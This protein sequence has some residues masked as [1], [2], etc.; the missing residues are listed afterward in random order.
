MASLRSTIWPV[1]AIS[2]LATIA[3]QSAWS[4]ALKE[5]SATCPANLLVAQA[6]PPNTPAVDEKDEG[7]FDVPGQP[8]FEDNLHAL[9]CRILLKEIEFAK[10]NIRF[11][12][13]G[14]VQGRWRGLRYFA[15]QETNS[16]MTVAGLT[17]QVVVREE[18]LARTTRSVD[19]KTG[20]VTARPG[21]TN[22]LVLE[23]SAGCQMIGQQIAS[24]GSAVELGINIY[25]ARQART[26]G[27]DRETALKKAAAM[28]LELKKMLAEREQ[29]V[30]SAMMMPTQRDVLKLEGE[31]LKDICNLT[32]D[33]YRKVHIGNAR[34]RTFQNTLFCG[35][36]SRS[37]VGWVGNLLGLLGQVKG[38]PRFGGPNGVCTTTSGAIIAANP[39]VSRGLGILNG[40][41]TRNKLN[42]KFGDTEKQ[43]LDD[44][45][46]D[47]N[48]LKAALLKH[49]QI[50]NLPLTAC[51]SRL[52]IYQTEDRS[53]GIQEDL[54]VQEVRAG[55]RTAT[56]NVVSAQIVGDT[57]MANGI[58][59]AI[60]G[61]RYP[62]NQRANF[63]LVV[64]GQIAYLAGSTYG[65]LD[66]VRIQVQ[67]ERRRTQ[68]KKRRL[69][70]NQVYQDRMKALDDL[71]RAVRQ[72]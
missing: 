63:P 20:Q 5:E 52:A 54:A 50:G 43:D 4:Q 64:D 53:R 15:S 9:N 13:E 47:T 45:E 51:E 48:Q 33:E 72:P 57:K 30:E 18:S 46:Q 19:K 61:Y 31:V 29:L 6:A 32:F 21:Q 69:L 24:L 3:C 42:R 27:Y 41:Y 2:A 40:L 44:F 11:R 39:I 67:A 16:L 1:I 38:N 23:K 7:V 25:H 55:Q 66:N 28:R 17:A 34:F 68:L 36:F 59:Q 65:S 60:A 71:E 37:T 56:Q 49:R 22:R 8:D 35:D 70:P 62:F 26:N 12:K 14:N 10:F 58:T